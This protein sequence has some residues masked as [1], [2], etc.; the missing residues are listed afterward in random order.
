MDFHTG[1]AELFC[2]SAWE[3]GLKG[4]DYVESFEG[5]IDEFLEAWRHRVIERWRRS[6]I[7]QRK[8]LQNRCERKGEVAEH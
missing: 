1:P 7:Q 6:D 2:E 3:V 5:G 4:V 8:C